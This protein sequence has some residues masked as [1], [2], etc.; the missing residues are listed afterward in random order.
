MERALARRLAALALFVTVIGAPEATATGGGFNAGQLYMY[1]NNVSAGTAGRSVMTFQPVTGR[2]AI[3]TDAF[4]T[5]FRYGTLAYD[6]LRDR[7]LLQGKLGATTESFRLHDLDA[8]GAGQTIAFGGINATDQLN[9]LA[10]GKHVR[11]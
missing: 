8:F 5:T 10:P 2:A 9:A 1:T 7:L 11:V 6:R 4:H 3:L